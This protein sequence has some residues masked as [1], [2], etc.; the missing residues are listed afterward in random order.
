MPFIE[1]SD[2]SAP[3][4]MRGKHVS[5]IL[6][7][8]FRRVPVPAYDRERLE[9]PDGDFVDL[10]WARVAPAN[11][12]L[13]ILSHGLEGDS[14]GN[15][16]LGMVRAFAREGWDALAWNFR[17]CSGEDNRLLRT[18]HGGA[19]D[20][21]AHVVARALES[22]HYSEIVLGGFSMGGNITLKYLGER[23]TK[24][25]RR[26]R[27]G[28]AYSVPCHFADCSQ[29]L[30]HKSNRIYMWKFLKTLREKVR[31]KK[32]RFPDQVD[33]SDLHLIKDFL[34]FDERFTAP[35]NGFRD[36]M[37]YWTSVSSLQFVD[38]IRVP[39]LLV[40]AR[41]DP[42]LAPTCFPFEAAR[43]SPYFHFEAPEHGGHVGFARFH[44]DGLYWS[45][46]RALQFVGESLAEPAP[47]SGTNGRSPKNLSKHSSKKR[48]PKKRGTA[49]VSKKKTSALK[50]KPANAGRA[51][52][53]A[54]KP[55]ATKKKKAARS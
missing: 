48:E 33:D 51:K 38:R 24:I 44:T 4:L 45:E 54:A 15:Y 6:P 49:R 25:D 47:A 50:S 31:T 16:I 27:A 1:S 29:V 5:T 9:L 19:S 36:A 53:A 26:I 34:G 3:K 22:K 52:K 13:L 46:K 2:Y 35:T 11:S 20:D 8:L 43:R 23:S 28:V 42:F 14:R 10:D 17:G 40:N 21:L 30:A 39:T 32:A 41:N 55:R 12:R 7:S 37:D 18:Y